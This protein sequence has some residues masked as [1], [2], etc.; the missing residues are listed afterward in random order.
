MLDNIL[1]MYGKIAFAGFLLLNLEGNDPFKEQ[2]LCLDIAKK[3]YDHC[4]QRSRE[5]LYRCLDE[6]INF[7]HADEC[8]EECFRNNEDKTTT[9]K[10]DYDIA[11]LECLKVFRKDE[12]TK[13][14]N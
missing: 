2:Q 3:T 5:E 1:G 8:I 6:C 7:E 4:I 14:H 12:R 10:D 13:G 9:C 11:S